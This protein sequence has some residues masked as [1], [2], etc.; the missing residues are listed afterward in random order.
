MYLQF[1]TDKS[2]GRTATIVLH[3][4]LLLYIL[5][6]VTFVYD[7]LALIL[8]VSNNSICKNIIF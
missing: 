4:V 1:Q 2:T 3:A 6:T 8:E 7:L 5:S